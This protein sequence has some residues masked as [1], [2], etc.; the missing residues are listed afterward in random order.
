MKELTEG[1]HQSY[2]EELKTYATSET[3]E[4]KIVKWHKDE[5]KNLDIYQAEGKVYEECGELNDALVSMDEEEIK[6]EIADVA[7]ASINLL[8]MY[9]G[10]TLAEVIEAK[11]VINKKRD[12]SKR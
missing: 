6:A 9:Y 12:W 1:R 5:F 11:M 4:Q 7:I 8:N 10:C 2:K 3:L